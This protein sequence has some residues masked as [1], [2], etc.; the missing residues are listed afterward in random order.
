MKYEYSLILRV[1][2]CFIPL[3]LYYLIFTP[4]TI[5]G[6]YILLALYKPVII[7]DSI[8]IRNQSFDVVSACIAGFAYFLFF[9]LVL[10]TKDIKLLKRVKMILFGFGLIYLFNILRIS[11]LVFLSL[12]FGVD[13]FEKV[14]MLF[15]NLLSGVF[16]AL[17]WILLVLIF[18]V[19][20]I[21]VY[22]D[23]KY[24][25]KRSSFK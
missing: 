24:L 22:S 18:K 10:L 2:L 20:D 17:I 16:V 5:Y 3:K 25:Y 15:W 21:P 23:L 1:I 19:K 12:N 9:I 7:G 11:L 8:F 4:L 13:I 14:H 6:S